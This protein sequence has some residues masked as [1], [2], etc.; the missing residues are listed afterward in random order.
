M[1]STV[2]AVEFVRPMDTGRTSPLLL[3]C[4]RSN[5]S[6]VDVVAKFAAYCDLRATNLAR[7]VIAACLAGDLGLPIQ[8]PMLIQIPNGWSE[9]IANEARRARIDNSG[10]VA[11]GCKFITGGYTAWTPDT[12]LTEGMVDTA[13]AIFTFDAIVQNADRRSDNP[14]CLVRGDDIRIIDH[15]MTFS[16]RLILGW[17]PPWTVGSLNWLETKGRHIFR[18]DLKRKTI[19]LAH[20]EAKWSAIAD[21]RIA[22]YREVIPPEWQYAGVDID[23]ALNLIC[24]ARDRIA[25]CLVEIRRVL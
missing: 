20:C 24:D 5:G 13:A 18:S 4:E 17:R 7:E 12:H 19:D 8:E 6:L 10:T 14:N 16:H 21:D 15:E 11:F 9:V 1:I 2:T 22:Q 3:T 23:S 25:D